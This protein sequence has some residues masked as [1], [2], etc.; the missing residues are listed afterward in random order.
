MQKP[1]ASPT[2]HHEGP[3]RP[4]GACMV[5]FVDFL[6]AG[7]FEP[8]RSGGGLAGALDMAAATRLPIGT[9]LARAMTTPARGV[10]GFMTAIWWLLERPFERPFERL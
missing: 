2:S 9:I 3:D 10:S 6:A 8:T 4:W 1:D 7:L 5:P